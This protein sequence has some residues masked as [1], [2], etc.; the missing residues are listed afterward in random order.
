MDINNLRVYGARAIVK[1]EKN[2]N[3]SKSGILLP[4]QDKEPT[5]RG[6]VISVGEG[7]LLENGTLVP[8]KVKK[9]DKIIYTSWSGSPID[10]NGELYVI[11]NERDILCKIG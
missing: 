9:G 5:F 6:E 1:E 8:M 3:E 7:A 10:I 2:S 11:I 4:G